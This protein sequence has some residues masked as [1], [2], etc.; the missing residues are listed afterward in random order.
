MIHQI[1]GAP[2]VIGRTVPGQDTEKTMAGY[3]INTV[4]WEGEV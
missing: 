3:K 4:A 2:T 1:D